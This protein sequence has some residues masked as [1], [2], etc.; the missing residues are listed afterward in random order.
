MSDQKPFAPSA[1]RNRAPILE[2]LNKQLSPGD[3]VFEFG[4]G[5]GQHICYFASEH[6]DI[7]WQ[8]SDLADKLPGINEWI[9]S[10]GCTNILPPIELDLADELPVGHEA[11]VCYTANTFHI[12]SWSL[13]Q[14]L[15]EHAAMLLCSGGKLCVYG[16]FSFEGNFTSDGNRQ[17]DQQLRG[18]NQNQGI[19]EF[20][21]LAVLAKMHG[22]MPAQV[23]DLPANNCLLIWAKAAV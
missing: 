10:S 6:L 19:R 16:P 18:E 17:F 13:V 20:N 4:S 22:F 7:T 3:R 23:V 15:F 11:N 1:E 5:T 8:P 12:I 14:R 21:D 2:V 9:A